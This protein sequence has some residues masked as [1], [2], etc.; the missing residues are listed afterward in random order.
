TVSVPLCQHDPVESYSNNMGAT[1]TVL[2]AVRRVQAREGRKIRVAFAST[3]ALYGDRGNDG[4]ALSEED[5]ALQFSSYYAAQKHASEQALSLYAQYFGI[6]ALSFRFFN[7]YGPGQDPTSPYS[8]VITIFARLAREGKPL[9]LNDGGIQT[10]DF[11][12]VYDLVEALSNALSLSERAWDGK[13][14]NLGTGKIITVREL[15]EVIR[16]LSGKQS[17]LIPA[18][19]R[20]GDVLHSRASIRRA[21]EILSF[22]PKQDFKNGLTELI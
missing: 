20:A 3:A 13:A 5:V 6:P 9:Q 11:V 18:P 22:K 7:V 19:A 21:E 14:I 17:E 4:R 16:E 15:A 1:L 12:S 8:G 2:D 10:R